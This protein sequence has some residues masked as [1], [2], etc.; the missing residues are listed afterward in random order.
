MNGNGKR[1]VWLAQCFLRITSYGIDIDKRHV[2]LVE[3]R[4]YVCRL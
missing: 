1:Y 2:Q 3:A 4:H